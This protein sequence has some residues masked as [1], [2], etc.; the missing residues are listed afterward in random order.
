MTRPSIAR[1]SPWVR[2]V[3]PNQAGAAA[4]RG[5]RPIRCC[6]S[7]LLSAALGVGLGFGCGEENTPPSSSPADAGMIVA[8]TGVEPDGGI[9]ADTGVEPDSGVGCSPPCEGDTPICDLMTNTCV[10]CLSIADCDDSDQCTNDT[11]N[12]G[13][14]EYTYAPG[15]S[16]QSTWQQQSPGP[17]PGTGW[18]AAAY[19][20]IADVVILFGGIDSNSQITDE[21][22]SWNGTEWTQLSPPQ[23]PS[24]RFTHGM[25]YSPTLGRIVLFGGVSEQFG[26]VGL[27]DT[28]EWTGTTWVETTPAVSPPGR[29][30]HRNMAFDEASGTVLLFGGGINPGIATFGDVWS[31]DGSWTELTPGTLP[32]SRVA[33]CM[34]ADTTQPRILMFG[35]GQWQ[36][37]Y[38]GDTWTISNG[39]FT[40]LNPAMSPPPLQSTTC[41]FDSWTGR[42]VLHGGGTSQVPLTFSDATWEFDGATWVNRGLGN[43]PG[44]SCCSVMTVNAGGRGLMMYNGA[45]T[46]TYAP[47]VV[48]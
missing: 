47:P 26:S 44:Q 42:Y 40:E 17:Q 18:A 3:H 33:A 39:I 48:P 32:S 35:G 23:S 24:P 37:P 4:S 22:W 43:N 25:A 12:A 10:E 16:C 19:D 38:F 41:A 34:A 9:I 1:F 6:R 13:A 21:T 11:C 27:A 46:W 5:A 7:A 15:A 31:Y 8:D 14:C 20:P 30:V 29:G 45:A 28:W 2:S 36:D